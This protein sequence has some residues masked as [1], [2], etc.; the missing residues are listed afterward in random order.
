[1]RLTGLISGCITLAAITGACRPVANDGEWITFL[2]HR[3]GASVLYRMHPDGSGLQAVFGGELKDAPGLS[4]GMKWYRQPHWSRQSPNGTYFLSW[5]I[6]LGQPIKRY[7]MPPRFLLHLGRLDGGPTRLITPDSDEIFAWAPDSQRF[8]YSRSLLRHPAALNHPLPPRTELVIAPLDGSGEQVIL[9]R[10]G[11]WAAHDWSLDGKRLL[12]SYQSSH[13]LQKA[14]H[15]LFELD[16][17]AAKEEMS[18][19][20]SSPKP[21]SPADEE[22][23]PSGRG[24]RVVLKRSRTI[25]CTSARY[26]PDGTS[27]ALISSSLQ[28]PEDGLI[29]PAQYASSFVLRLIDLDGGQS[30]VLCSEPDIFA[31]P[32]SWSPDGRQVLFARFNDKNAAVNPDPDPPGDALAIWSIGRDGT[33]ARRLTTGW[34][35]DWRNR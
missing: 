17:D 4:R 33:N 15:A 31:G 29:D 18:R 24:L 21:A 30:R 12:V 3:T 2:S 32:I 14:A 23:I 5:A 16:L 20:R 11:I 13:I 27:V 34:C 25:L 6:D 7:R 1:M 19:A 9:D 35:P 28:P 8:V 10:L 22:G 26:A